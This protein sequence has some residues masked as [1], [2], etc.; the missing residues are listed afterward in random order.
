MATTSLTGRTRVIIDL[1]NVE[2]LATK[3]KPVIDEL[4]LDVGIKWDFGPLAK[5][6]NVLLHEKLTITQGQ[7][8]TLNLYDTAGSALVDAFGNDLTMEAIKFLFIKNRSA[9]LYVEVFGGSTDAEDLLIMVPAA[10]DDNVDKLKIPPEGF[11][12]WADPSAAG[13]VTTSKKNLKFT[14][15]GGVGS[16]IIDVVAMGKD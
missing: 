10:A 16:A 7:A 11:F 3:L 4:N 9:D 1:K 15:E 8:Q 2:D 14:V 12:L 6:C 13:I 5:Q